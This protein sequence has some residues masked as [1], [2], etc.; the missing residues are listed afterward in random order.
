MRYLPKG[1]LIGQQL[2]VCLRP[3]QD[4]SES[5]IDGILLITTLQHNTSHQIAIY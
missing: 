5:N 2:F 1:D 4:F 3:N